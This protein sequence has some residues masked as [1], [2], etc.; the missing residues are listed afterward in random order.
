MKNITFT[1]KAGDTVLNISINK[2][3]VEEAQSV[4]T[5]FLNSPD[6]FDCE[7]V[8]EN[9]VGEPSPFIKKFIGAAVVYLDG[10]TIKDRYKREQTT[11]FI[12]SE[13]EK[14]SEIESWDE[15]EKILRLIT[16]EK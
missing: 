3:T 15:K 7:R 16:K 13:L 6:K 9:E 8:N 4:I 1:Y 14:D 2:N 10:K 5:F 11:G 12:F